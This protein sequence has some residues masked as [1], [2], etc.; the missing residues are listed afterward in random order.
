MLKDSVAGRWRP[1]KARTQD[2]VQEMRFTRHSLA[3]GAYEGLG[4]ID[5]AV[6]QRGGDAR[7]ELE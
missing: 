3:A 6:N 4:K 5:E 2:F 7:G 1:R